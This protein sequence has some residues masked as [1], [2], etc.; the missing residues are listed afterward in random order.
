MVAGFIQKYTKVGHVVMDLYDGL[1]STMKQCMYSKRA[2]TSMEPNDDVKAYEDKTLAFALDDVRK[3]AGWHY[4]WAAAKP[5]V[6]STEY[7]SGRL[8]SDSDQIFSLLIVPDWIP[9]PQ[10]LF[11][12]LKCDDITGAYDKMVS[13]DFVYDVIKQ[14]SFPILME[15]G[16]EPKASR[17]IEINEEVSAVYGAFCDP[18]EEDAEGDVKILLDHYV[19][20][21]E[22][23][24][25]I[26]VS[27][28]CPAHHIAVTNNEEDA[29]V[30]WREFQV[31]NP[32]DLHGSFSFERIVRLEASKKIPQGSTLYRYEPPEEEEET[33]ETSEFGGVEEEEGA[34]EEEESEEVEVRSRSGK[35]VLVGNQSGPPIPT[36]K[37]K[38]VCGE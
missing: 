29:N 28:S 37:P 23:Q 1:G 24:L 2:F 19:D 33:E 16:A 21:D 31:S 35:R 12:K 8:D 10:W 38:L 7:G 3:S 26:R 4:S 20:S 25:C 27:P 13:S 34:G 6:V 22:Q 18:N 30:I 15:E 9:L 36:K 32:F 14:C 17:V 5:I 11:T